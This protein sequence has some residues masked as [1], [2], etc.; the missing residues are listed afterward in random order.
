VLKIGEKT[1]PDNAIVIAETDL[2]QPAVKVVKANNSYYVYSD[3][4]LRHTEVDAD[5]VIRALAHYLN[6]IGYS[7]SKAR[8]WSPAVLPTYHPIIQQNKRI[9]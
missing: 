1:V 8:S 7:L 2:C 4:V 5:G 3:D 6:G 9:G